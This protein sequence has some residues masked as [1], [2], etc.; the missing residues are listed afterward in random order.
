MIYTPRFLNEVPRSQ[1][2]APSRSLP[3]DQF[4]NEV[5]R[6]RF[7]LRARGSDGFIAWCGWFDDRDDFDAFL[8]AIA[9]GSLNQE[10]GLWRLPTPGWFP[11]LWGDVTFDF[12]TV[13]FLTGSP[14]SNQNYTVPGDWNNADNK[15]ECIGAGGGGAVA[16]RGGTGG[17]YACGGGGGGYGRVDNS[18]FTLGATL[19][20]NVGLNGAAATR[21][22][23]G[24]TGGNAAT[25]TWFNGTTYAA[26]PVGG[27]GSNGGGGGTTPTFI[28]YKGGDN[29]PGKG[30]FTYDS[31]K[32]G[33]I[34]STSGT[35]TI[36]TGGGGAAGLNGLGGGV[37][38]IG[39]NVSTS[40]GGATGDATFGGAGG[41]TGN[42]TASNGGNGTE[43]D[44]THGSG[45]G[46]G[47]AIGATA[48]TGGNGG[49][50]GAGGGGAAASSGTVTSGAG[51]QG[52]V[53]VT[54]TPTLP[55]SLANLNIPMIGM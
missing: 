24:A 11:D 26:A 42:P 49:N 47:G 52:I 39:S 29:V 36:A 3:R 27:K 31:G 12:A 32:G 20:Y 5:V 35:A 46:G 21:S 40:N 2:M 37:S 22:S 4:G 13:T 33:A 10:P 55:F 43:W 17:A 9:T 51:G 54:Y 8:W 15:I 7:R 6:T 23:S 1:W 44:A 38:Q 19:V 28:P 14:G 48:V 34:I 18:S 45:G 41:A 50:Y 16:L 25:D 30:T 53:V